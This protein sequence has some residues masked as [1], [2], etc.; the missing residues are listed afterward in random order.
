MHNWLF[1]RLCAETNNQKPFVM[2]QRALI[3]APRI[4]CVWRLWEEQ[5]NWICSTSDMCVI[6]HVF[7]PNA[8]TLHITY[9]EDHVL[10]WHHP[11]LRSAGKGSERVWLQSRRDFIYSDKNLTIFLHL[12]LIIDT[13]IQ[14]ATLVLLIVHS[15]SAFTL[16]SRISLFVCLWWLFLTKS[17]TFLLWQLV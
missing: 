1:L 8:F 15:I 7:W 16:C 12:E 2:S 11:F 10:T 9:E 5:Q 17:R 4:E 6:I 13:V 3:P 14:P